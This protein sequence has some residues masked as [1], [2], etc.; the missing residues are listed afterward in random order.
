MS[1]LALAE[2]LE[3][4]PTIV[5]GTFESMAEIR[6]A[7]PK[8]FAPSTVPMRVSKR[9]HGGCLFVTSQVVHGPLGR[10]RRATIRLID[11]DLRVWNVGPLNRFATAKAANGFAER[12]WVYYQRTIAD[13]HDIDADRRAAAVADA[14]WEF[15][16][17]E[18]DGSDQFVHPDTSE[19]LRPGW[20]WFKVLPG[21][22]VRDPVPHGPFNNKS[23]AEAV[24][25]AQR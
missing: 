20:Y 2:F 10:V 4:H 1:Y 25:E 8:F 22:T 24:V 7:I 16:V 11:R 9:L 12:M 23:Q 13:H 17:F 14:G 5:P 18:A 6:A 21:G 15:H 19:I 3:N